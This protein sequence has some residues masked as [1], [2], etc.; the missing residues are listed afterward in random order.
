M[1]NSSA[2]SQAPSDD[3]PGSLE[4]T[5]TVVEPN[6]TSSHSSASSP[7]D[8]EVKTDN[9]SADPSPPPLKPS[10]T[11]RLQRLMSRLGPNIYLI[12]FI[13]I[14]LLAGGV[15]AFGILRSDKSTPPPTVS[16]QALTPAELSQLQGSNPVVGSS[17]ENLTIESNTSFVGSVL[18][19]QNLSVAGNVVIGGT[20]GLPS[21]AVSG[22]SSL[23]TVN[24]SSLNV[25]GDTIVQG[26][27]TVQKNLIVAG[28]GS[29]SGTLSAPAISTQ[30]LTLQG[31]LLL[32]DHITTTG[33]TPSKA[34]GSALGNGG[35]ASVSGNDTAG[36]LIINTG[37]APAAGCFV[38][39][40][41][42]KAFTAV[43]HVVATPTN[44]AAAGLQYYI[45]PSAT[46][47]SLCA[48]NP[49]ASGSFSFDYF[50]VG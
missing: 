21:I 37:S 8:L 33:G 20:L 12:S 25:T 48:N 6:P 45:N 40:T 7:A 35:T 23:H 9:K 29:F 46:G 47:F 30:A 10:L 14:I 16:S 42:S 28:T 43:P 5:S 17:K 50:V 38:S 3:T 13:V 31:D 34:D 49:T 1:D 26:S 39:L 19:K 18:V 22:T 44:S 41:F 15:V 2:P 27:S 4:A 36:S 32:S 24:A 11:N